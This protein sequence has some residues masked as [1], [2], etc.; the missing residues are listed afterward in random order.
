[1]FSSGHNKKGVTCENERCLGHFQTPELAGHCGPY[2]AVQD[3]VSW[4]HLGHSK[5]LSEVKPG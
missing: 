2:L 1:M 5:T 4:T 3:V